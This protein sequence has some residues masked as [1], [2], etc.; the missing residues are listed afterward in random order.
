MR[1]YLKNA[2]AKAVVGA[3]DISVEDFQGEAAGAVAD[4]Q[5]YLN[6][7]T[8]YTLNGARSAVA[9]AVFSPGDGPSPKQTCS[10]DSCT[11]QH[12]TAGDWLVTT[13]INVGAQGQIL[14]VTHYRTDG[15]V[16]AAS[17]YNY[18][19]TGQK[20]TQP[21]PAMPVTVEQLTKLATDPA[22]G[23]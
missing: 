19:P 22:L 18:D 6:S 15:A 21:L 20:G 7:F 17:G 12:L 14:T 1:T 11:V 10:E 2:F 4:G 3:T 8:G 23:I 9:I 13:K 5:T 16:V